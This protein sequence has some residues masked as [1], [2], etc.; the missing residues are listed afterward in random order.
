MLDKHKKQATTKFSKLFKCFN[1]GTFKSSDYISWSE[2]KLITIKNIDSD[3]FNTR[4]V[5]Y[6]KMNQKYKK[7]SLKISDILL[8]MTGAYLGRSGIVDE[9]NCYQNQRILK[10]ECKSKAFCYAFLKNYENTIFQL[11]RG[12]AQPN[13]SL[14]DLNNLDINYDSEAVDSF[15]RYEYLF[16]KLLSLKIQNKKLLSIK[17]KLLNIYF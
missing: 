5:T 7:Y 4:E 2:E 6:F 1:G 3:G 12:S 13:L 10:V 16:K 15:M 8:T 17:Q 9:E 14:E 11:G